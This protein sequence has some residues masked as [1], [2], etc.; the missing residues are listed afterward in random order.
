MSLN[1]HLAV[2]VL[3][4][5]A[6]GFSNALFMD[7]NDPLATGS[8]KQPNY[9]NNA[10]YIPHPTAH[11]SSLGNQMANLLYILAYMLMTL[12]TLVKILRLKVFE[13]TLQKLVQVDFMGQV[14]H[15]L[16]IK[17]AW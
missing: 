5:T 11:A 8:T 4:Q 1:L 10:T 16:G 15:F 7:L 3:H 13:Q 12:Y 17:F 9:F 6:I 14:S 2:L